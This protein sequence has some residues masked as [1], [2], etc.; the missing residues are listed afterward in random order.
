MIMSQG[1]ILP[2][3]STSGKLD[4]LPPDTRWMPKDCD[5]KLTKTTLYLFS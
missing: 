5:G 1:V 3:G 2:G 4:K